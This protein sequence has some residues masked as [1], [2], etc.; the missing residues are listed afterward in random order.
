MTEK[1]KGLKFYASFIKNTTNKRLKKAIEK[2]EEEEFLHHKE[3]D[4]EEDAKN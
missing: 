3:K 2:K 1:E 4:I